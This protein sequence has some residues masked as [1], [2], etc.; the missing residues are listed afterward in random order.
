MKVIEA[1]E[2]EQGEPIE[3]VGGERPAAREVAQEK[4]RGK[5]RHGGIPLGSDPRE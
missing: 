2:T 4:E 1:G 5:Y 3:A